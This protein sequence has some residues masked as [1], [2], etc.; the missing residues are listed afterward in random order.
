MFNAW[1]RC[2]LAFFSL[3]SLSFFLSSS[4]SGHREAKISD[5]PRHRWIAAIS[6]WLFPKYLSSPP[7]IW[8]LL[9]WALKE[10]WV[11]WPQLL[12]GK[13]RAWPKIHLILLWIPSNPQTDVRRTRSS[14][15][16][17]FSVR[18]SN[19]FSGITVRSSNT[20]CGS[21]NDYSYTHATLVCVLWST[22]DR[23]PIYI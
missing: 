2:V 18:S 10:Q 15:L 20:Q 23:Q 8:V 6:L 5:F 21:G 19:G 3:L 14:K 17:L 22:L 9:I 1:L 4:R 16:N 12:T 13:Q 11:S 7:A